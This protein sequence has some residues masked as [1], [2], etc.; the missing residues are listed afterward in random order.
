MSTVTLN[1]TVLRIRGV[2]PDTLG[3]VLTPEIAQ[4]LRPFLVP[5]GFDL[6][7]PIHVRELPER[8]GFHLTQ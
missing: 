4:A 8:R 2:D 1:R 3:A 5:H 7:R 6:E